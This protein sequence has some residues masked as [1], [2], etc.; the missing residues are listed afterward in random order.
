MTRADKLTLFGLICSLLAI[1]MST[2]VIG[3]NRSTTLP[4]SVT[5]AYDACDEDRQALIKARTERIRQEDMTTSFPDSFECFR[6][7][8][9][10][11][12]VFGNMELPTATPTGTQHW[13]CRRPT[14]PAPNAR[15]SESR[16]P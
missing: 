14:P 1:P 3:L 8:T 5:A 16:N 11:V 12:D 7:P 4:R 13:E 6:R 2:Y 10:R 9:M 15:P